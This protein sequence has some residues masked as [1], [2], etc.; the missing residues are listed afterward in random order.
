V[1]APVYLS[2]GRAADAT[3]AFRT[4]IRILGASAERNA[5]LGEAIVTAEDGIVTAEA[6]SA[7]EAAHALD[8]KAPGPRFYL[9]LAAEQAGKPEE[10]K[11][12]LQALL[13]DAPAAAPW[14]PAVEAALAKTEPAERQAALAGPTQED[15]A[16]A[17]NMA[18]GDR[19]AMIESMVTQLA[20]RLKDEPDDVEGWLRLIRS[21][22][23]LGR[24]DAAAEAGRN[25]LVGVRD[26]GGRKRVEALLADLRVTPAEATP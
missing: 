16:E 15:V 3:Q 14:R 2:L 13:A 1:I 6:R 7:F 5:G 20:A 11:R 17:Q 25:A 23:V 24:V 26:D 4:A 19:S 10:A 9:A 22:V 21:Y 12:V 8:P 18:E